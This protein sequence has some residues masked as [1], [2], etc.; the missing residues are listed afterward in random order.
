[1]MSKVKFSGIIPALVTPL[2]SDGSVKVSAVKPLI[3]RQ[4]AAGVDGFYLTGGT[5]EGVCLSPE[6]RKTLC[7]AAVEA[8]A[9]RG[10]IIVHTGCLNFAE[11]EDYS[12]FA[13]ECGVDAISSVPPNYY[14]GHSRAET[15][16]YYKA[17]ADTTELP[18]VIYANFSIGKIDVN[19][20]VAELLQV[21][22]IIGVKDTRAN[23]FQMQQ[24]KLLNGGDINVINGPDES[25]ICGLVMGADCGI[26]TTYNVMPDWFVKL[27]DEYRKGNLPEA[28]KW[29]QKINRVIVALFEASPHSIIRSVKATL[30]LQGIDVG[31]CVFPFQKFRPDEMEVL[32]ELLNKAGLFE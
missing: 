28:Q 19:E 22:N 3:D 23:Y 13:S 5:G 10:K 27:Y 18:I 7:R 2:N 15:I 21:G 14:F 9:G 29:Q 8:N 32:R 11:V 4:L 1:M 16:D 31:D 12:R 24:L 30:K 17:L 25:L 26:G 20:M 6:Q